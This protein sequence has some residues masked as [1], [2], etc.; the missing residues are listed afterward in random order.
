VKIDSHQHFWNYDPEDYDW[1]PDAM[2]VIRRDFDASDLQTVARPCGI[3]GSV[4]V[5]ARQTLGETE[6]LLDLADSDAFIQGIVGWVP[7][8]S[9][10]IAEVLNRFSS[11]Q[12]FKGVR[13][14]LQG[15]TDLSFIHGPA[16][17]HGI[18]ALTSRALTYDI[19]ITASQLPDAV[20]L[21]DRHPHQRFV[22]DHIAKPTIEGPPPADWIRDLT[23]LAA[24]P[25]VSCKFS[26]VV[27]EVRP[28]TWTPEL[29]T[30]YFEVVLQAFGPQRLMFGS[31]WPVCLVRSE[32]D[33]WFNFVTTCT[34]SLSEIEQTQILGQNAVEF[35]HL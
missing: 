34:A 16:F 27:S 18:Q 15:Q 9:P 6:W 21:V 33:R 24:R 5:Q 31:D 25:Q 14:V 29:L 10:D 35:Y 19:L 20:A 12:A 3:D 32:Y 7:L 1:I 23:A 22:L 13:H 8:V 11:R 4:V 17:T 26:G 30:P 28:A 2:A